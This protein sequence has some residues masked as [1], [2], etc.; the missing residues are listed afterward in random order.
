MIKTMNPIKIQ[1]ICPQ[2]FLF[3][4][5]KLTNN[6]YKM[7]MEVINNMMVRNF[8]NQLDKN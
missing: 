1:V 5:E 8:Y 2:Y 4:N 3:N 7:K 6:K